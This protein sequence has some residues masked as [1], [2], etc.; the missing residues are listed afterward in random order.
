[1]Q[2][3]TDFSKADPDGFAAMGALQRVADASPLGP[4]LLI[5]VKTRASQ[6]NGCAYDG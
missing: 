1:M 6:M 2:P 3:R 5:L 4:A